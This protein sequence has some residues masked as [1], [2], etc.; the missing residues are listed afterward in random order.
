[1]PPENYLDGCTY[2]P[3]HYGEISHKHICLL[4]DTDYWYDRTVL[5]KIWADLKWLFRI[6]KVHITENIW[7]WK[8]LSIPVTLIGYL[9]LMTVGWYFW[10]RR[11]KF[12]KPLLGKE[13]NEKRGS[14]K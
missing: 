7:W 12:D 9:G 8:I 11:H 10:N 13:H 3:D 4:H 1:M 5:L 14:T 6:I 2:F